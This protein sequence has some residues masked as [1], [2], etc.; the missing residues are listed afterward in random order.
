MPVLLG[1]DG[2]RY[3]VAEDW[4]KLPD[5][6]VLDADVAGV[7][8][9]KDDNVYAFNRGAHP[10]IVFDRNGNFLRSWGGASSNAH[11]VFTWRRTTRF[12]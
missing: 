10:M 4:A 12:F 3:E 2:F 8:I 1:T 11:T 5:G 9:D 7:G 6:W